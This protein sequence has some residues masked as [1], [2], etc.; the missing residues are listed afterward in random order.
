MKT[1]LLI[2]VLLGVVL[3]LAGPTLAD[4]QIAA[5]RQTMTSAV[6]KMDYAAAYQAAA[7]I[8]ETAAKLGPDKLTASDL[9]ALGLARYYLAAEALDQAG[10]M[11]GLTEADAARARSLVQQILAAPPP[12]KIRTIAH[13]ERVNL[14]DY[15]TPGKTTIFDFYSEYCY[16]C[17][18][19]APRIEALVQRRE[20]LMLVKVDLNRPGHVGIDW[21][22]PVA[23]QYNMRNIP[24]LKIYGPDGKLQAEGDKALDQTLTWCRQQ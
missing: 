17:M 6:A 5:S 10:K 11:E 18:Q 16:P 24:H 20:D 15:L 12:A 7:Q 9:F 19:L 13:G 1:V 3:L 8:V 4:D 21:G 22:S 14:E 23:Q 2:A